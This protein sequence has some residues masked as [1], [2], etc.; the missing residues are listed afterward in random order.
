MVQGALKGLCIDMAVV[1]EGHT[2]V[3]TFA[4]LHQLLHYMHECN[5]C[6]PLLGLTPASAI[7]Q[8]ELPEAL[9]G[10]VRLNHLDLEKAAK[11]DLQTGAI[12]RK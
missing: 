7:I 9:V 12:T 2:Q 5:S 3:N 1:L 10:S 8:D 6:H 11:L 4:V